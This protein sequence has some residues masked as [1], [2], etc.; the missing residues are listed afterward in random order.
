M[1]EILLPSSEIRRLMDGLLHS[2]EESIVKIDRYILSRF[3]KNILSIWYMA[4]YEYCN[5]QDNIKADA[6]RI[7]KIKYKKN[8]CCHFHMPCRAPAAH[9]QMRNT[10]MVLLAQSSRDITILC[11]QNLITRTKVSSGS[12]TWIW[13]II[14]SGAHK[15]LLENNFCFVFCFLFLF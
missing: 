5:Y 7:H 10:V 9:N 6:F 3:N 13:D 4:C 15:N 8:S 14:S 12:W 2:D 1:Q 11:I